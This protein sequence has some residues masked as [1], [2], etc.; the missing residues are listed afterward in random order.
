MWNKKYAVRATTT[1]TAVSFT[2]NNL[3]YQAGPENYL[4]LRLRTPDDGTLS[5]SVS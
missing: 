5:S 1:S 3:L 4:A 2:P